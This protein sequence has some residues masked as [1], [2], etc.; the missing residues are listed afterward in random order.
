MAAPARRALDFDD[1][2]DSNDVKKKTS[3][4]SLTDDVIKEV[5][6]TPKEEQIV[7]SMTVDDPV[8]IIDVM[9]KLE[10]KTEIPPE[11]DEKVVAANGEGDVAKCESNSAERDVANVE[12]SDSHSKPVESSVE[13]QTKSDDK[14]ESNLVMSDQE[15][16]DEVSVI[17]KSSSSHD[18][19]AKS[20][21]DESNVAKSTSDQSNVSTKGPAIERKSYKEKVMNGIS[22][23]K[24]TS[25]K[26]SKAAMPPTTTST[27]TAKAPPPNGLTNQSASKN[28]KSTSR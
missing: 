7:A 22:S 18:A 23:P 20:S 26:T 17:A 15:K 11:V 2:T 21:N 14:A 5:D 27:S 28:L 10:D 19:V 13:G 24:S 12:Q 9:P 8:I 4:T 1:K 3:M 16:Q 25:P 6:V